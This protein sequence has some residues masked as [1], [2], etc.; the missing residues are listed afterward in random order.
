MAPEVEAEDSEITIGLSG[1]SDEASQQQ[2]FLLPVAAMIPLWPTSN[3]L[4]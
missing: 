2:T 3:E 4:C 1:V